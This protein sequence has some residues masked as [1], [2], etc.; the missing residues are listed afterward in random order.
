MDHDEYEQNRKLREHKVV[1]SNVGDQ[2]RERQVMEETMRRMNK[3][4][5]EVTSTDQPNNKVD[6]IVRDD[7][8]DYGEKMR[9]FGNRSK[10]K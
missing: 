8:E 7:R 4:F 10:R 9:L 2:E 5:A 3:K 6:R 1:D